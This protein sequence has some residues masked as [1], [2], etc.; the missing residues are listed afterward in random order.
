MEKAWKALKEYILC[1]EFL[2]EPSEFHALWFGFFSSWY[3]LKRDDM[4]D[5]LKEQIINEYHY[6]TAGF[7]IGRVVQGIGVILS[8]PLIL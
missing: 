7:W 4:S 2:S 1:R 8:I 5:E 3:K 6:F